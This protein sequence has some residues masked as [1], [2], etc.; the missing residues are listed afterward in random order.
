MQL[1]LPERPDST[2]SFLKPVFATLATWAGACRW[3]KSRNIRHITTKRGSK[4][5]RAFLYSFTEVERAV[6]DS[7]PIGFP[8]RDPFPE[9]ELHYSQS[10]VVVP[11]HFFHDKHLNCPVMIEPV[12]KESISVGLGAKVKDGLSSVFTRLGITL[13]SGDPVTARRLLAAPSHFKALLSLSLREIR[14]GR[15]GSILTG[16]ICLSSWGSKPRP[17][18]KQLGQRQISRLYLR[19]RSPTT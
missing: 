12:S 6:L 15:N 9:P 8:V 14:F 16:R 10:L 18:E 3:L 19:L 4:G 5:A 17:L 2:T 13:P 11:P 1:T 7:L